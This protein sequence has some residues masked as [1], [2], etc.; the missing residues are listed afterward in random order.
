[1]V[2]KHLQFVFKRIPHK[3]RTKRAV[4]FVMFGSNSSKIIIV[5]LNPIVLSHFHFII[6]FVLKII[7]DKCAF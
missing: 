7:G 5:T 6:H 2:D 4:S 1:M 3:K